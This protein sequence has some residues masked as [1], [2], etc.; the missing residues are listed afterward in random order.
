MT[1]WIRTEVRIGKSE[2]RIS[3]FVANTSDFYILNSNF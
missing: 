1:M 2:Y 3:Y